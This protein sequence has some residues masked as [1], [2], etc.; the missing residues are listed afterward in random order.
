MNEYNGEAGCCGITVEEALKIAETC[1]GV[2][3]DWNYAA[4]TLAEE[5]RR[6]RAENAQLRK[7]LI[8]VCDRANE[9]VGMGWDFNDESEHL[10][11]AIDAATKGTL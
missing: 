11:A 4:Q 6:L 5:V 8:N 10:T 1:G 3:R 9:Y 7:H 2:P